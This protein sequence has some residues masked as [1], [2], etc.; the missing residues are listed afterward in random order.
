M[1]LLWGEQGLMLYNDAYA[2]IA[3]AR[4]PAILGVERLRGLARGRRDFNREVM[5]DASSP[6]SRRPIATCRFVF[7]RNGVAE[8]VWLNVDY[9]PILDE[10][11]ACRRRARDRHRDDT[12][13]GERVPS[14]EQTLRRR[15]Q[16]LA[17]VQKIGRVG[18]LEVDLRSGFRNRRSPEYLLIHGL[19]PEAAQETP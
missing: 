9:S 5:A 2:V 1:T 17:Q 10:A 14:A 7:Y 8:D 3:G 15:E 13:I 16:E 12:L 6:A 19:P 4:H 11:G 18:G